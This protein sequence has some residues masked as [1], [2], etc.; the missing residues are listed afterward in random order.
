MLT[1]LF[2]CGSFMN[3]KA[4]ITS[5]NGNEDEYYLIFLIK[6]KKYSRQPYISY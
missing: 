2:C 3:C 4:R 1:A 5:S 6:K